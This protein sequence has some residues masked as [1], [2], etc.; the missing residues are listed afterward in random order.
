MAQ[1]NVYSQRAPIPAW[2]G[3]WNYQVDKAF[4]IVSHG[5]LRMGLYHISLLC[6]RGSE[7]NV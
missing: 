7:E 4:D 1:P 5:I 6:G 3:A 2:E